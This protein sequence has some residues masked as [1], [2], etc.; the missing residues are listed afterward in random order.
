M[1]RIALLLAALVA[2]G[3]LAFRERRALMVRAFALTWEDPGLSEPGDEGPGVEWFDDYYTVQ[4]IDGETFAIS[5]PRFA[6]QNLNYLILGSTRALLFDTGPGVRD[7]R[8]VVASLTGLPVVAV[9][10]HLHYDHVGGHTLYDQ[11]AVVDLPQLRERAREG[12]LVP[13]ADEHLGFIEGFDPPALN[14]AEWWPPDGE[15]ELGDRRLQVILT[16]GHTPESI[17]LFD[18]KRGQLFAGDAFYEGAL[19]AMLPGSSLGD[20]LR[21][22]ETLLERMDEGVAIYGA[23]RAGPPGVPVLGRTDVEALRRTL[24]AI[25]AGS[26]RGEGYPRVFPVNHRLTLQTDWA[27]AARWD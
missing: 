19:F 6:Q 17:S 23:H 4:R 15:V 25:R 26:A 5:E 14:V 21:T 8:P 20:Y 18:R 11:V 13:T 22:S 27:W 7:I 3:G 12:V 9:P 24:L 1:A 16:P 10:S 2:L